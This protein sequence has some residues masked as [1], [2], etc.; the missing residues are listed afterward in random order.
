MKEIKNFAYKIKNLLS[1]TLIENVEIV[2]DENKKRFLIAG[3]PFSIPDYFL[4]GIE[5]KAF[6]KSM[7]SLMIDLK[8][9][10]KD[11]ERIYHRI[12]IE[13]QKGENIVFLIARYEDRKITYPIIS[14]LPLEG[15]IDID[16]YE[17]NFR[18]I[19]DNQFVKKYIDEDFFISLEMLEHEIRLALANNIVIEKS[20]FMRYVRGFSPKEEETEI[21]SEEIDCGKKNK[22]RN[23]KRR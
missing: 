6:Y 11:F 2:R 9:Y 18:R 17:V 5:E 4:E 3:T 15:D 19:L 20:S 23:K 16:E 14:R 10:R 8:V 13:K 21:L 1:R 12:S 7:E 22:N